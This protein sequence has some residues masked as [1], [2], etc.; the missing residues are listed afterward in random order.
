M[1]YAP[2]IPVASTPLITYLFTDLYGNRLA[3]LPLTGV[4]FSQ[5]LNGAGGFAGT[6]NVEDPRVTSLNWVAA[7]DAMK[8]LVWVVVSETTI[9][10][11]G[12]VTAATYDSAAQTVSITGNDFYWYLSRR[13]QAFD[14]ASVWATSPAGAAQ[15]AHSVANNALAVAGS[16]PIGL[17]APAATP[18]EYLINFALP[19]SQRTTIDSIMTQLGSLGYQVGF[20]FACDVGFVA[21]VPTGQVTISYPRRGRVAGTTGLTVDLGDPAVDFTYVK[22]GTAQ[23]NAIYEMVSA[24]GTA[25]QSAIWDPAI[26]TDN[27]PLT[28]GT[29]SHSAY[30]PTAASAAVLAA[31]AA[32]DLALHAYPTATMTV[33]VP[34]TVNPGLGDFIMGDDINT[35]AAPQSGDDPPPCPRFPAGLDFYFR[36][37]RND[38]TVADDGLS[39]M[40]LTLAMPPSSTPQRPP[41]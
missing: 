26:S 17:P 2:Q 10:Y 31:W 37:I 29:A 33:T 34:L 28:E 32:D 14:Y 15:I 23:A 21:G 20:D 9:V 35:V 19:I 11:G 5:V 39:T 4:T 41:T 16:V 13:V 24:G 25:G 3:E 1:S 30:S 12:I 7:T 22:D 40:V 6:L 27:Y 38:V 8:T 36:I 18:T